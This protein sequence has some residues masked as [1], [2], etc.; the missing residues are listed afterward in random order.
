MGVKIWPEIEK[1]KVD[2]AVF[3]EMRKMGV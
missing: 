1:G 3:Q 2:N